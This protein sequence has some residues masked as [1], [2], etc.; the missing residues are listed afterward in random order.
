MGEVVAMRERE[1]SISHAHHE[2]RGVDL[3]HFIDVVL[4]QLREFLV[5]VRPDLLPFEVLVAFRQLLPLAV[6]VQGRILSCAL[7]CDR[8]LKMLIHLVAQPGGERIEG[9]HI[10]ANGHDVLALGLD[11][12]ALEPAETL[13]RRLYDLERHADIRDLF[14]YFSHPFKI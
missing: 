12:D 5:N 14:S 1:H 9:T 10:G 4:V 3:S 11:L 6:L 8:H 2:D 13:Q 7:G